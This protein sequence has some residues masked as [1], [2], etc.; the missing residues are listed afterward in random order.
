M[1]NDK[2]KKPAKGPEADPDKK[3]KEQPSRKEDMKDS[4]KEEDEGKDPHRGITDTPPQTKEMLPGD[5]DPDG[6]FDE[7]GAID[8]ELEDLEDEEDE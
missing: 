1:T 4:S 7:D 2:D 8:E 6:Y 5:E 3:E